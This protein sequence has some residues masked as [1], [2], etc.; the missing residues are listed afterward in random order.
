M[1]EVSRTLREPGGC[2]FMLKANQNKA[3]RPKE[4]VLR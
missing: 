1:T 4:V 3:A 2:R